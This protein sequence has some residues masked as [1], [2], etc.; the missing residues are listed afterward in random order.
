MPMNYTSKR[1]GGCTLIRLC[2]IS[3]AA[4]RPRLLELSYLGDVVGWLGHDSAFDPANEDAVYLNSAI[5]ERLA[6]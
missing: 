3:F 6:A 1:T 5:I 4:R 2:T